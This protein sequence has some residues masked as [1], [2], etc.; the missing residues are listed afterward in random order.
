M[1]S[2]FKPLLFLIL[3]F[4]L[5]SCGGG[6]GS[7]AT[8]VAEVPDVPDITDYSEYLTST[9]A[10]TLISTTN[11]GNISVGIFDFGFRNDHQELS[12]RLANRQNY[13][14]PNTINTLIED[15]TYTYTGSDVEWEWADHGTATASIAAG[16][17]KGV[18]PQAEVVSSMNRNLVG[19]F[20]D[21][22]YYA[23]F[24]KDANGFITHI[25]GVVDTDGLCVQQISPN[26]SWCVD[27]QAY[28]AQKMRE[29][30]SYDMPAINFSFTSP[31]GHYQ[32]GVDLSYAAFLADNVTY[33]AD[34]T[35]AN[36]VAFT[37]LYN[38]EFEDAYNH[39]RSLLSD[40]ELVI[41]TSAGNDSA[42]LTTEQVQDWLDLK[43]GSA[44][45]LAQTIVNVFYDPDDDADFSG[46]IE[47]AER[48]ITGG[49]LF[50]GA[51]NAV[52]ER[53]WY[54]NYPGSSTAV[55]N[56]FVV[57]SGNITVAQ[58]SLGLDGYAEGEGTS[59]ASPIV[60]G[61]IA[62]LKVNHPGKT[63]RQIA[64]AILATANKNIPNYSAAMHGQGLLDVNAADLYLN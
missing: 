41:V 50:V 11:T 37:S 6:G 30:A 58:A 61:A 63:A 4:S 45:P 46:T 53:T 10:S 35:D 19:S 25:D 33:A 55:Q 17:Y 51:L 23:R 7:S 22:E 36:I 21:T 18:A 12:D 34:Y 28:H 57:A 1:Q 62:L 47:D 38:Y 9:R 54:S 16:R 5:A 15:D 14:D 32:T 20:D 24:T 59:F 3:I 49:I 8:P 42:S 43:A 64:D 13:D 56:R 52:G 2:V 29:V 40:G 31:F 44:D 48:G 39:W 27:F 60:A 26:Y